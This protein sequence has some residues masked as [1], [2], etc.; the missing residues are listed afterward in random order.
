M[1]RSAQTFQLCTT[2]RT[3]TTHSMPS[4]LAPTQTRAHVARMNTRTKEK[5]PLLVALALAL[6]LAVVNVLF[7]GLGGRTSRR[8]TRARCRLLGHLSVAV[9]VVAEI[10]LRIREDPLL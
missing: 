9:G 7:G 10:V 1:Q 4:A 5:A 6:A 2:R 3:T 8:R